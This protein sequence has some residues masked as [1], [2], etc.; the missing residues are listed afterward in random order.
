[1]YGSVTAADLVQQLRDEYQVE[2]EKKSI[3]LKHPIKTL[4]LHTISVRLKEEITTSF[5]LQIE[6]EEEHRLAKETPAAKE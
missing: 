4:G 3:Q 1:M 6:S 5:Q 2:V